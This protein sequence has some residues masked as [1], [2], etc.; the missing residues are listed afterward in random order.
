MNRAKATLPWLTGLAVV[1]ATG[2]WLALGPAPP[3]LVYDRAAIA[4]G[5]W[6]RLVTGHLVHSDAE[7]ALWDIAALALIGSVIEMHGRRRLALAILSG[8]IGVGVALWWWLPE[9]ERY[10]GLSG[11]LNTLFVLAL[12]DLWEAHRHPVIPLVATGLIA[13]LATESLAQG[14]LLVQ[15]FWPTVPEAHVAGCLGGL[16][17]LGIERSVTSYGQ[18]RRWQGLPAATHKH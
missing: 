10:C 18:H 16:V 14:S 13:K 2:L 7:H 15:T 1:T 4:Q 17:F 6:W 9:L 12:H 3:A 11:V 8:M 5:E